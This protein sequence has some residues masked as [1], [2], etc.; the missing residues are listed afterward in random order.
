M[1]GKPG[2]KGRDIKKERN[3]WKSKMLIYICVRTD[4]N[5][6]FAS[7]RAQRRMKRG[8]KE[9]HVK[10]VGILPDKQEIRSE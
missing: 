7:E 4:K 6:L 3:G 1:K 8:E 2:D 5:V 10:G 9:D